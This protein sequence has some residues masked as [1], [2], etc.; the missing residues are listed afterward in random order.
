MDPKSKD[1][2]IN[3]CNLFGS[4]TQR[5]QGTGGN[6]SVKENDT[7]IIKA[8][9][10]RLSS[11]SNTDG[12]VICSIQKIQEALDEGKEQLEESIL[13]GAPRKPSMEAYFHILPKTII[14]HFH[15]VYFCKYLCKQTAREIFT[16]EN[17]PNSKFISYK[18]PGLDL[19]KELMPLYTNESILFLENHGIILLGESIEEII[20]VYSQTIDRLQTLT[21]TI[22]Y[23]SD[24]R[25]EKIIKDTTN[26]IIKPI[27]NFPDFLSQPFKAV[28]PDHFL[29]LQE[30]PLLSTKK[31]VE[32]DL[33]EWKTVFHTFPSIL[34][35]DETIYSLAQTYEQ[36]QNKEEYLR[37][38]F[39]IYVEAQEL[40]SQEL[41]NLLHCPKEQFRLSKK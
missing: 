36:C 12:Y 21:Q 7:L 14:V 13:E 20:A 31:T 32:N 15:S 19:A 39:D 17:F 40:D 28:T 25:V 26:Q 37:S 16:V 35:V 4:C 24:L 22:C 6:I 29:F 9:G 3:L 30:R 8:S 10:C 38:Y 27:Y 41:L 34:Q 23:D 5:T 1:L 11:V 2:F 18:K 33:K